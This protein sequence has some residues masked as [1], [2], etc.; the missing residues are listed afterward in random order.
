MN[1][2]EYKHIKAQ[3]CRLW[4]RLPQQTIVDPYQSSSSAALHLQYGAQEYCK[5][6][7]QWKMTTGLSKIIFL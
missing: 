2:G 1:T 7:K 4:V 6:A 3:K 5:A